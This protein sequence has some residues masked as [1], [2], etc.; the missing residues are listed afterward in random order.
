M[1]RSKYLASVNYALAQKELEISPYIMVYEIQGITQKYLDTVYKAL[2]Q[3]IKNSKY[4][5]DLESLL[6][7]Q[8]AN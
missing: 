7:A 3:N 2:P 5:M 8:G 6:T 1:L 4:G